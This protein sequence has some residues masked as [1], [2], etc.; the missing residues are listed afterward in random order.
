[1]AGVLL[2]NSRVEELM[3][4]GVRDSKELTPGM[5]AELSKLIKEIADDVKVVVVEAAEVDRS[6]KRRGAQGLNEL[7]ARIFAEIIDSLKPDAAYI[8][9]L[10]HI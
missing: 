7:E 6:T 8:L 10:I 2:D 3:E 5:R 4:I 9:P 1:M